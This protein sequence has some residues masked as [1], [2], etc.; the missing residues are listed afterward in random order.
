LKGGETVLML[1]SRSG[2]AGVVKALLAKAAKTEARERHGQTALMWAAAEGNTSVVRS[3]L[4]AGADQQPRRFEIVLV[5][6]PM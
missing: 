3:L 2:N 4:D 1:A 5:G 6:R